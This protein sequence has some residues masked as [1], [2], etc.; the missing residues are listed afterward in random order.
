MNFRDLLKSKTFWTAITT[1]LGS[2]GAYVQGAMS[3]KEAVFAV[4]GALFALF[5][6]DSQISASKQ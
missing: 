6:K 2:I 1:I 4:I 5:L 3:I